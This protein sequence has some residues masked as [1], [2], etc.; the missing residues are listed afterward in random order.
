MELLLIPFLIELLY[1]IYDGGYLIHIS[2]NLL[3]VPTVWHSER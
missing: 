2:I 3:G 1:S